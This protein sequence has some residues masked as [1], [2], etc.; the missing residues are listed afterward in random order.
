MKTTTITF[1]VAFDNGDLWDDNGSQILEQIAVVP[2]GQVDGIVE[3]TVDYRVY[4]SFGEPDV[5]FVTRDVWVECQGDAFV[6]IDSDLSKIV[7]FFSSRI[8]RSIL[9]SSMAAA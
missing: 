4:N 1:A 3:I 8:N 5:D 6:M 2:H 9:E 7:D